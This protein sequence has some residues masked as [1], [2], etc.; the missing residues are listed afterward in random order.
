MRLLRYRDGRPVTYRRYDGLWVRIGR[1]LPWARRFARRPA[2]CSLT[3]GMAG[4][5]AFHLMDQDRITRAPWVITTLVSCLP[6]LVLGMGTA[7]AHM[8]REDA[9][10]ARHAP[11]SVPGPATLHH[12]GQGPQGDPLAGLSRPDHAPAPCS[13]RSPASARSP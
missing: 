13:L 10:A 12:H 8:L 11:A 2:I 9:A 4:Q 5:V 1:H 3:L 7:L 6:V